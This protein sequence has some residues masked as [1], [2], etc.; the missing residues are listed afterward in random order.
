LNA[1]YDAVVVYTLFVLIGMVLAWA[2]WFFWPP[3]VMRIR[4]AKDQAETLYE[5]DKTVDRMSARINLLLREAGY[6]SQSPTDFHWLRK[7]DGKMVP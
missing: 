3:S 7:S 4:S 1:L 6:E 5:L 2:C